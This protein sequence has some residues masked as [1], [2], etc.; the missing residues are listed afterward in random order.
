MTAY[1]GMLGG[2]VAT[3]FYNMRRSTFI[4]PNREVQQ[5][6]N[7]R[8]TQMRTHTR[9]ISNN[10][11]ISL[12]HF[13]VT[14]LFIYFVHVIEVFRSTGSNLVYT[15]LPLPYAEKMPKPHEYYSMN[16]KSKDCE[17]MLHHLL[18]LGK[19]NVPLLHNRNCQ[20]IFTSCN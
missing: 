14:Q 20:M 9:M 15:S 19:D 5:Q 1:S 11:K 6:R 7:E 2:N 17:M 13:M 12:G 10:N 4:D 16:R 8:E 18:H 3:L